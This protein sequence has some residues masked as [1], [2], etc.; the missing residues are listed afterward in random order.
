ML[1]ESLIIDYLN[2]RLEKIKA[3]KFQNYEIAARFRDQER[4]ISKDLSTIIIPGYEFT[5]YS[6]C[7][8]ILANYCVRVYNCG[9]SDYRNLIKSIYRQRKL[10][11]LGI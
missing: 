10:R 11:D 3:I 9:I 4:N 6:N 1:V 2:F 7:A 8:N 5:S